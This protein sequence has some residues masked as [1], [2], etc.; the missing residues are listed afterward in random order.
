MAITPISQDTN[1]N[2]AAIVS[3]M[4]DRGGR[5]LS[6][7]LGSAI[8]LGRN[9][10]DNQMRQEQ[11]FLNEQ[12][13]EINLNQRR[14]QDIIMSK[15]R[16]RLFDEGKRRFD[17]KFDQDKSFQQ[18]TLV[19]RDLDRDLRREQVEG[20]LELG[21]E[22]LALAKSQS[23]R[24]LAS[25]LW[26]RALAGQEENRRQEGFNL[27]KKKAEAEI[28]QIEKGAEWNTRLQKYPSI[29]DPVKLRE[30]QG[31][32][33][34]NAPDASS[35][36]RFLAEMGIGISKEEVSD[37]GALSAPQQKQAE[38]ALKA[39]SDLQ[40]QRAEAITGVTL[41]DEERKLEGVTVESKIKRINAEFD[42]AEKRL[43]QDFKKA[44][45]PEFRKEEETKNSII[46]GNG[47]P[48]NR[49]K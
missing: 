25:D 46:T 5:S 16:D 29:K 27:D 14:A 10:V 11:S 20:G 30:E 45:D 34:A 28:G 4:L 41:T 42:A 35:R 1:Q 13:Q 7:M 47:L 48:T 15:E 22:N 6:Q 8:Q 39:L 38:G 31:Y 23:E 36:N 24:G 32:L 26:S 3:Q 40:G 21:K 43:V 33:A 37:M 19:D 9:A 44:S 17:L 49:P 18:E 2:R 12:R